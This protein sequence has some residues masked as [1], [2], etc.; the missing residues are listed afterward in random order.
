M[1]ESFDLSSPYYTAGDDLNGQGDWAG[2]ANYDAGNIVV[3]A[4]GLTHSSVLGASGGSIAGLN[5]GEHAAGSEGML[6]GSTYGTASNLGTSTQYWFSAL[7]SL[8]GNGGS[9][10]GNFVQL[11]LDSTSSSTI[12]FGL[13]SEGTGETAGTPASYSMMFG[14][15]S[16]GGNVNTILASAAGFTGDQYVG[17][18]T[19]LI[20]GRMTVQDEDASASTAAGKEIF[21]LWL[22]PTDAT[23]AATM[24]SSAQGT[25]HRED[26]N[27][28]YGDWGDVTVGVEMTGS[29]VLSGSLVDE[30]R[31]GTALSDLNLIP[32]PSTSGLFFGALALVAAFVRRRL[33]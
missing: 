1:S 8:T 16:E 27:A 12:V 24:T 17:G 20:V 14:N 7:V 32:E 13:K 26:V 10:E 30:I 9:S 19:A 29:S 3:N 21:D 25:M 6:V 5:N 28:I 23:S 4:T 11:N 22:N 33:V 18:T 15:V 31:V 2:D